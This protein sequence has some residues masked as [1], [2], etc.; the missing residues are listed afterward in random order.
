MDVAITHVDDI[1]WLFIFCCPFATKAVNTADATGILA[2][3]LVSHDHR[4]DAWTLESLLT[5]TRAAIQAEGR[6]SLVSLAAKPV[7]SMRSAHEKRYD[8]IS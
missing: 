6:R 4:I 1:F 5:D 7:K 8:I 2:L 3:D